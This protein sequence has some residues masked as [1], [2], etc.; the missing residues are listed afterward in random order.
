MYVEESVVVD[1]P[2]GVVWACM[3]DFFN[4]PRL[5]GRRALA[6]RQTSPGPIGVGTTIQGRWLI[7]GFEARMNLVIKEWD[8]PHGLVASMIGR[9]FRPAEMRYAL[10]TVGNG[11][12]I[13]R[14]ADVELRGPLNV[15]W[16]LFRPLAMRGMREASRDLKQFIESRPQSV[17]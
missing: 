17:G 16:P 7:F 9:P 13:V 11:T 4:V 3:T 14:S 8:P 5:W 12:R 15:V 1:R 2:I 10:E 6:M